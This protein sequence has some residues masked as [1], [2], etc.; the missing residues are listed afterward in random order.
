M[1]V[2]ILGADGMLGH[3]VCQILCDDFDTYATIRS[4]SFSSQHI[5][6]IGLGSHRI[7][8]NIDAASIDSVEKVIKTLKPEAVINCIGIVKQRSEAK[9]AISSIII[10]AL[11]PHQLAELCKKYKTKLIHISTD[12]VFSGLKGDYREDD[13][14]DPIDLYGRSKLLGELNQIS[15]LTLRTSIIGWEIKNRS[16]L[17][18]W[19][20][21]Q[22]G[23]SIKGF[24]RAIY[25]GISSLTLA[26]LIKKLLITCPDLDGLYHISS[27]KITKHK[28][29]TRLQNNLEWFDIIIEEDFDFHCDRSLN[30]TLFY[31]KTGWCAPTWDAMIEE[32]AQ[33]WP[34][35]EKWR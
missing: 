22:R 1:R 23:K 15:C 21:A 18:E 19:F 27:S 20:A 14:P 33:E 3:K 25:T 16:S 13:I 11:F 32:L 17:L 26:R 34:L 5:A 10:N 28:L 6:L 9:E 7:R 12:C 35:Y 30:S 8:F 31:E 24:S 2:L 4:S 29:L